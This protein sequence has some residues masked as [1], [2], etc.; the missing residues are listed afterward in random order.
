MSIY[1]CKCIRSGVENRDTDRD[2]DAN[3]REG[4]KSLKY[5][6]KARHEGRNGGSSDD[7]QLKAMRKRRT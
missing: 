5:V 7:R 4:V 2:G 3:G 1:A 6:H